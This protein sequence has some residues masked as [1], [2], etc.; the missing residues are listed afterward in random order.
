MGFQRPQIVHQIDCEDVSEECSEGDSE[1]INAIAIQKGH[2]K[3][4]CSKHRDLKNSA[5]N[6][7]VVTNSNDEEQDKEVNLIQCWNCKKG[8]H[9]AKFCQQPRKIYCYA[10]GEPN[11]TTKS[12]PKQQEHQLEQKNEQ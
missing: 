1:V 10:C 9:M 12:C 6:S 11:V 4:R 3:N 8:G 2:F 7:N 5:S